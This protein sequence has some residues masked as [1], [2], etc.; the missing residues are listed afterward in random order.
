MKIN[1]ESLEFMNCSVGNMPLL[2]PFY[3]LDSDKKLSPLDYQIYKL[4]T[5]L[6]DKK[7]AV[8]NLVIKY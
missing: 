6:M 8:Y 5:N 4:R 3:V 1:A 2:I 7:L